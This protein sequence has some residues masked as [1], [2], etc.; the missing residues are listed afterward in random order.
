MAFWS[1][2]KAQHDAEMYDS[3]AFIADRKIKYSELNA[4]RI[5]RI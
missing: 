5:A 4:S 1:I 3:G 2:I